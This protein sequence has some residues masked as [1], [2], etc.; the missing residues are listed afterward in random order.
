MLYPQVLGLY[1]SAHWCPPCRGFTPELAKWYTKLT[2]GTLKDKFD[3][4]FISSDRDQKQFDEYFAEMPWKCLPYEERDKKAKL[5]KMFKI[6]GIPSLVFLDGNSGKTITTDGRAI[7]TEDPEGQQFPWAPKS[8]CELLQGK[9]VG[10]DGKECTFADV[11]GKIVG[12]Y[13]SA[14]W[15]SAAL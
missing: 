10:K 14:H 2:D 3:I 1:F 6:T 7:V 15:V 12:L 5:A 8:T 4:V 13:F 11:K 9:L